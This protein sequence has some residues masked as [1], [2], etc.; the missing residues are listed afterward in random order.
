MAWTVNEKGCLIELTPDGSTDFAWA[1]YFPMEPQGALIEEIQVYFNAANDVVDIKNVS[2]TGPSMFVYK[3]LDGS[4]VAKRFYGGL[5]KPYIAA[6]D[7]TG[8]TTGWQIII[9]TK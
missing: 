4:S 7:Q 8:T 6:A 9:Q 3:T 5:F 1:T 2:A